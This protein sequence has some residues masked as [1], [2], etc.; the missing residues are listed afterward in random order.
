M[1]VELTPG[2]PL[3]VADPVEGFGASRPQGARLIA[4][5][6]D[7][8]TVESLGRWVFVVDAVEP[9]DAE[10]FACLEE[11]RR[12]RLTV[13]FQ[14]LQSGRIDSAFV[15]VQPTLWASIEDRRHLNRAG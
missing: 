6:D 2:G 15:D 1:N 10:W 3:D 9:M 12:A 13:F 11:A 4:W 5:A 7:L 14:S 8:V